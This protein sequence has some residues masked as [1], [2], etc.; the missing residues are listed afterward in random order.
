MRHRGLVVAGCLGTAAASLTVVALWAKLFVEGVVDSAGRGFE[1]Q[2]NWMFFAVV[3][4]LL[5]VNLL[6][7]AADAASW[8]LEGRGGGTWMKTGWTLWSVG[9]AGMRRDDDVGA[10]E[11]HEADIARDGSE[12]S[13]A[14]VESED[15]DVPQLGHLIDIDGRDLPQA[16]AMGA[17]E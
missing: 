1:I 12:K 2:L 15:E 6:A 13:G 3:W 5:L 16:S 9:P 10:E 4:S 17:Q 14:W 11:V 7:A 8:K